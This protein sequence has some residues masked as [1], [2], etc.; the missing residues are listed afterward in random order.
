MT[1]C[2]LNEKERE[3]RNIPRSKEPLYEIIGPDYQPENLIS[4]L[5]AF[6]GEPI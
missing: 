2:K 3:E 6:I 4:F 1:E 5:I